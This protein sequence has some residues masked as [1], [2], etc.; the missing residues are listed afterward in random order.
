MNAVGSDS[1]IVRNTNFLRRFDKL[2]GDGRTMHVASVPE[3]ILSAL[4]ALHTGIEKVWRE[5]FRH[6]EVPENNV[7]QGQV[8]KNVLRG[9]MA[10]ANSRSQ[11][12]VTPTDSS[13]ALPLIEV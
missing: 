5:L 9:I 13:F 8:Q 10:M 2:V 4:F 7:R 12:F 3:P 11:V 6:A 1:R